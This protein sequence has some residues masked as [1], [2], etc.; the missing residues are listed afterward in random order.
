[1]NSF[2]SIDISMIDVC[3]IE[4]R[5]YVQSLVEIIIAPGDAFH[6]PET[7]MDRYR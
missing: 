7:I 6:H 4:D 3:E 5:A 2:E 1:M